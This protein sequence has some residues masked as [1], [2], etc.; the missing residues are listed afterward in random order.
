MRS[1]TI[2]F[3]LAAALLTG[4]AAGPQ[5]TL[6]I[7]VQRG[8]LRVGT[9]GDYRP[10]SFLD[11]RGGLHGLDI[12]AAADLAAALSAKLRFVRTSW[13]GLVDGIARRRYDIAMG[14]ISRPRKAMGQVVF[15]QPYLKGGKC[16]LV[17]RDD[18]ARYRSLED[19]DQAGLEVAVT[20]GGSNESFVRRRLKRAQIVTIDDKRLIPELVGS[21][22][23]DAMLADVFEVVAAARHD[24]HLA[25]VDPAHPLTSEPFVYMVRRDD[26]PFAEWLDR[27]VARRQRDGSWERLRE[28]WVGDLVATK[29]R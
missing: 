23:V 27:W 26:R 13:R 17:R 22:A 18:V 29:Q 14:G 8:E 9:T 2:T 12:D 28:R 10:F 11:E 24:R 19:V 1:I 20:P 4:C 25:A 15:T 21:G 5:S 3:F 16:L 6:D 7:I